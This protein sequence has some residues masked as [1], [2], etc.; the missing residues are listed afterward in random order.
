MNS[1]HMFYLEKVLN[2][3]LSVKDDKLQFR[4]G[5]E[6]YGDDIE[7]LMGK[8][9]NKVPYKKTIDGHKVYASYIVSLSA[10]S[11]DV[12]NAKEI[13]Y[14]LKGKTRQKKITVDPEDLLH[15]IQRTAVHLWSTVPDI[16]KT[17][18]FVTIKSSSD[19][20]KRL[21]H[22][23]AKKSSDHTLIY[24]PD[25]IVKSSIDNIK[26][27]NA[28]NESMKRMLENII[29]RAKEN[30]DFQMKKVPG[31]LRQFIYNFLEIDSDIVKRIE[32]RNI[33]LVDDYLIT[34]RTISESFRLIDFL[35]PASL[36]GICYFKLQ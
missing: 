35:A 18:L 15:F 33:V 4:Y 31:Q 6:K 1:R 9:K 27:E 29:D 16:D 14:A 19:F 22:E 23:L 36:T 32:G 2:D 17:D 25:S 8:G 10:D 34:G 28:P 3:G 20:S 21:A 12:S 26:I 7:L 5:K 11:G 13:L 30:G 24:S